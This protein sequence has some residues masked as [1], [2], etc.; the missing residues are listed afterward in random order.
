MFAFLFIVNRHKRMDS[1]IEFVLEIILE[2]TI[3]GAESKKVPL[4]IRILLFTFLIA[5][6]G[7]LV[8]IFVLLSVKTG[9]VW[10]WILTFLVFALILGVTVYRIRKYRRENKNK[11][12]EKDAENK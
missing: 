11:D 1:L 9:S 8:G 3:A 10:M 5:I 2:G 6:Y 7:A 12:K 4:P